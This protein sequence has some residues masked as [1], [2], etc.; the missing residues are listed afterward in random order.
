MKKKGLKMKYHYHLVSKIIIII[1]ALLF[2]NIN[3]VYA[4]DDRIYEITVMNLTNGQPLSPVLAATH[5]KA[6]SMFTVGE[7]ASR[8]LEAIAED[9]D[10]S[11]MFNRFF[12]SGEVTRVWD[13][14][15]PLTPQGTVV[16]SFTDSVTFKIL[17]HPHDKFT[18]VTMLICTNDGF[19]GL[20]RVDLPNKGTMM[21]WLDGYDAGTEMNTELSEDIVDPC[22]ALGPILLPGDP[23]GNEDAAVDMDPHMPI[24]HHPTNIIGGNDLTVLDHG[25]TDPVVKVTITRID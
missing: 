14:G 18:M 1:C 2:L 4:E 19:T 25:W 11:L 24:M 20:D 22:S 3:E 8:G 15:V 16:G 17:A 13:V 9:G 21:Y 10:S 5:K 6:I 7:Q 23:N 12:L